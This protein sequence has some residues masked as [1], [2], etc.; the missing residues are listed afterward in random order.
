MAALWN[1]GAVGVYV[2]RLDRQKDAIWAEIDIIDATSTEL[3]WYGSKSGRW[4]VSG[5]VW[6][7]SNIDTLEGY[8]DAS[9]SRTFTGPNALSLDFK[10]IKSSS[11]RIPD[12]TDLTNECFSVELEMIV[13]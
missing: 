12:K 11:R 1:L 4:R 3:H 10:L 9:T 8:A 7:R 13:A 6:G 2:N 5:T